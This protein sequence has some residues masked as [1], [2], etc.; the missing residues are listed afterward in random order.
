M[1]SSG[2]TPYPALA[3]SA[4]VTSL[5]AEHSSAF[6]NFSRLLSEMFFNPLSTWETYETWTPALS[7]RSSCVRDNSCR[8]SR[9]S[10]PKAVWAGLRTCIQARD[11][12]DKDYKSRDYK[13]IFQRVR[14]SVLFQKVQNWF[15]RRFSR[16]LPPGILLRRTTKT[17]RASFM[18]RIFDPKLK[19]SVWLGSFKSRNA[20]VEA[21]TSALETMS[22]ASGQGRTQK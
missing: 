11:F 6:E 21:R 7:L 3:S 10:A 1:P 13:S 22:Q 18:V 15:H 5:E 16:P 20:A 2:K 17:G 8:R 9:T 12:L 19:K 4:A 14:K